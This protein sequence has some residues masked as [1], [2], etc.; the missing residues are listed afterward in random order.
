M[1]HPRDPGGSGE[2]GSDS[3]GDSGDRLPGPST[4][5]GG[6]GAEQPGILVV[7]DH[8]FVLAAQARLL[9]GMGYL[10]LGTAS[11]AESALRLMRADPQAVDLLICD[12]NMPG[13]YG[14]EFLKILGREGFKGGVILL[15][16]EGARVLQTVQRLL[17]GQLALL[18]ALEKPA[19]REGLAGLIAQW[20]PTAEA[21]P[22][23]KERAPFSEAELRAAQERRE[24]VLHYQ[25]K[26]ELAGGA[27]ASLE[28][29]I[30][31]Q[32]PQ[33]GLVM[34]DRFI[35]VAEASGL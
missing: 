30:R 29:L 11:S 20:R 22:A 8:P 15:S 16:G 4:A 31:W 28:A 1:S 18:G 17:G 9:R 34:P 12:L 21:R 6:D 19:T 23:A 14:I 35:G 32:H 5:G 25:P 7:D 26:V 24:W 10:R 3:G 13:M 2:P 33:Q 27:L